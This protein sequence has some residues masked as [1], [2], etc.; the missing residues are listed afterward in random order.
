MASYILVYVWFDVPAF[1]IYIQIVA[2][3]RLLIP[4]HMDVVGLLLL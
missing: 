4:V 3:G 1:K 2:I